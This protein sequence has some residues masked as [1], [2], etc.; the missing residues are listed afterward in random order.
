MG[1]GY[2][3]LLA[4]RIIRDMPNMEGSVIAKK[5]DCSWN[6]L[7]D[8]AK[9]GLIDLGMNRIKSNQIHPTLTNNGLAELNK[10]EAENI[11]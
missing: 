3:Q 7:C 2:E 5:A 4:L 6:E 10:A 1:L 11:I 9:R 8:L